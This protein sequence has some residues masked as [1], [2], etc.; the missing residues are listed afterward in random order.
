MSF[1]NNVENNAAKQCVALAVGLASACEWLRVENCTM[2]E[3]ALTFELS[4]TGYLIVRDA[5]E[6]MGSNERNQQFGRYCGVDRLPPFSELNSGIPE[7]TGATPVEN[8]LKLAI[9]EWCNL[10]S[11]K[12]AFIPSYQRAAHLFK[13]FC[14]LGFKFELIFCQLAFSPTEMAHVSSYSPVEIGS[15]SL[16]VPYG[17][18][19]SW[20]SCNHSAILQP[21]IVPESTRWRTKLNE[22]GL[23]ITYGA[24]VQLRNEY[25]SVYP[26]PPF[27]IF[28]VQG[29]PMP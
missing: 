21:G 25:L 9:E 3:K 23:L 27:D 14:G 22:N 18:D 28:L 26:Y 13:N 10:H 4:P 11:N 19:V 5:N 16:L 29:V 12:S 1:P 24:A 2:K 15:K 20:P 6:F 17:F 7:N 8:D